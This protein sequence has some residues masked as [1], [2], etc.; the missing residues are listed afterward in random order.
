LS[1]DTGLDLAAE[2]HERLRAHP[3]YAEAVRRFALNMLADGD[4]DPAIDGIL[5]DAGRSVAALC[6]AYLDASG[7]LTLPRLKAMLAGFGVASPGRARALLIFMR[8]LGYVE[9]LPVHELGKAAVY[10]PTPRFI[11][12]YR[13]HH[14]A[15]ADAVQVLEP[16]VGRMIERFDAPGVY[17]TFVT[18][19]GDLFLHG[20]RKGRAAEQPAYFRVFMHRN[21]GI[22]V[23]H[24]LLADAADGDV[25]PPRRPIAFS[26]SAMARRFK[27]SRIHISRLMDA[28][29][30]EGLLTLGDGMVTLTPSG[31]E[32]FDW[33]FANQMIYFLAA[34]ARTVKAMPGLVAEQPV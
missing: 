12:V 17:E 13:R 29:Q 7:G 15:V 2:S 23:V 22:Q 26:A 8:Y 6:A 34:A 4:G 19:M 16:A 18:Q 31:R 20:S 11:Q 3:R 27:V 5:K 25:F 1:W 30:A 14:R 21:A 24:A 10:R 32:A 33:V 28:A 9:L